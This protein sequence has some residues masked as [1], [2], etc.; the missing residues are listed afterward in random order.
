ME[1]FWDNKK[2]RLLLIADTDT[3]EQFLHQFGPVIY[4]R[5]YYLV[6]ADAKIAT[7]L[8]GRAVAQGIKNL[9]TFDPTQ[10]TLFQWLKQ[11]A[12]QSCEEALEHLQMKPQRPWAWSQLPDEV[13]CGL[14]R[15]RLDPLDDKI[16]DNPS[17]HEIAQA[18]LAELE[19]TDRQLLTHRYCH[20]DTVENIAEEMNWGIE[21]IENQLYRSRHSF[22]RGFF[23][24]IASTNSGFTESSDTGDI[25]VQ[26]TNLEKLLSTT[27]VYQTLDS[28]QIDAIREQL[29][30]AAEET[31][32][33]LPIETPQ[34]RTFMVGMILFIIACLISGTYWMMQ[35]DGGDSPKSPVSKTNPPLLPASEK[36][37]HS[38]IKHTTQGDMEE[39]E[40]K[41]VFSLG[42][43]GNVEAL[44]EVLKSGQFA[45]QQMIMPLPMPSNKF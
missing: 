41:R 45:S 26:E 20:L 16:L 34:P 10:E 38:E 31:A 11:E 25:E 9:S 22:R 12:A 17:V 7:D 8:T 29:L 23:Q 35:N 5:I 33:S 2:I 14:S 36:P 21:D 13:L 18:A 4:T 40:L 24:L 37:T 42:Q 43:A 15:F 32:Q 44:L 6:G 1:K 28:D 27:T 19:T 30:E 3:A 39:E